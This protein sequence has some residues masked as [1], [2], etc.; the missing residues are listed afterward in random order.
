MKTRVSGFPKRKSDEITKVNKLI[1][2]CCNRFESAMS[3]RIE[4]DVKDPIKV[5]MATN[6]ISVGVDIPRLNVMS[7]AGQPKTTAVYSKAQGWKEVGIV[8]TLYNQAK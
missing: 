1:E 5:A 3:T 2:H 6:M 7:I 4:G 8:F